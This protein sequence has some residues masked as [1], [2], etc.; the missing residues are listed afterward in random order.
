MGRAAA[1]PGKGGSSAGGVSVVP[2]PAA[3][4]GGRSHTQVGTSIPF[5]YG[6]WGRAIACGL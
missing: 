2:N 1:G 6:I 3:L 5:P 4:I